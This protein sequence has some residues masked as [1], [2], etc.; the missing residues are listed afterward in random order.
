M[1]VK[2]RSCIRTLSWRTF[3]SAR[4]RNCIAIAAIALTALLFTSLFTVVLSIQTSYES[5]TFRQIGGCAY[6]TFKS[7]TEDQA[8]ALSAHDRVKAAGKRITIGMMDSGAFAKVPAEVSFMDDNCAA[9][10]FAAPTTGRLPQAGKEIALDT[11]ALQLLGV[12][13]TVGAEIS[14]TYTVG[15]L[16]DRPY[17]QTETFTLVGWWDYD[18]LSPVHFVNISE[19]YARAMEAEATARGQDPFRVDLNVMLAS[20][21]D[22]R[23]QM[24]QVETDLGYAWEAAGEGPVV[25]IGVNWGYTS[26]QLGES[27]DAMTLAAIFAFL[28]LVIFTG[29]LIIY[30]IFQ[31]SVTGDVRFYGL[32]KTIGVTPRQLRRII[33]QQALLLC[34]AGIPVGL[35]LGYGVGALLT[36]VVMARTDLGAGVSTVSTSP[37]IFLASAL[38]A[39]VTVLLSC[40]RPGRLAAK[41]SPV[42]A[43]R[44][45]EGTGHRTGKKGRP[46]RGAK[47][48]HMAF[49]NLGR[50]KGKTVLVVVSLSLSVVLLDLLVTFTGGFDLE[51]YLAR[52]SCADFVVSSADYFRCDRADSYLS[53]EDL[54]QLQANTTASCSGSGYQVEGAI[55]WMTEAAWRAQRDRIGL[56]AT[57]EEELAGTDR[58]GDLVSSAAQIEGLDESLFSKLTLVE[59]DLAPLFQADSHA[60]ALVV[61]VDDYGQVSQPEACP[62]VGSAQTITYVEEGYYLDSRTGEKSDET[63]PEEFLEYHIARSRDVDYTICAYV[64]VPH[65]MSYRYST[66]GYAFVLP[67]DRVTA[68][69][70]QTPVPLFYLFDTPDAAAE[71]AAEKYL[72]DWTADDLSGLLYESK[73]TLRAEFAE[74]QT[75]FLLLGGLLCAVV[76]LVGV[77]NFTNAILTGIL[78]RQ[79]EFAVLQAVGMTGRQLKA[80]LV[81]EGLFYAL[82]SA[83]SALVLSLVLSPLVGDLLEQMFW[84]FRANCTVAPVLCSVPLF[85][86]LGW[87]IPRALY[88]R[89]TRHTLVDQLREGR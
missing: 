50:N 12:E 45:T 10:S 57:A 36:P 53:S 9:W 63:T 89:T 81:Q 55:G 87:L 24:E 74:F 6:G 14:L 48:H 66:L 46:A 18:D 27:L 2:N 21:V 80:M 43:T 35:L 60:I 61:P 49:A 11:R 54:A 28:A 40:A 25:P 52:Q 84:F 77:L 33:R 26:A 75:M 73:A 29:Y 23:G 15:P 30:T 83:L 64:T 70:G 88:P 8:A 13:P 20:A 38:F 31:I 85:A 72:A 76:G 78:A 34:A 69:S 37:G 42:E 47:V 3:R 32:L 86:L 39:L 67:V 82:A 68:D 1:H 7:V 58:R 65:A 16:S 62:P 51:T 56:S 79:R 4:K 17:E 71:E 5:Y 19:D 22:I 59:G 41:V 44:C